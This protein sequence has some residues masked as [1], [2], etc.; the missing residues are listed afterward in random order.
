MIQGIRKI[1]EIMA[2]PPIASRVHSEQTPGPAVATDED[3]VDFMR[4]HGNSAHHQAGTCKMGRDAMAVVDRRLRV[5]GVDRLRVVDA[6]IMPHLTSG[7]TN[8]PTI[9]IGA[10]AADMIAREA[11]PRRPLIGLESPSKSLG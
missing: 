11:V 3:I 10:K 7:N 4:Q 2:T 8:A 9:M 1:R 6:S 5:H